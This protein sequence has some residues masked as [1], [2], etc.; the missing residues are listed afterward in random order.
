MPTITGAEGLGGPLD[1]PDEWCY[2]ER[3]TGGD[4]S[5]AGGTFALPLGEDDV[6]NV[7]TGGVLTRV[8]SFPPTPPDAGMT[9]VEDGTDLILKSEIVFHF[10]FPLLVVSFFVVRFPLFWG[11]SLMV[12]FRVF[13]L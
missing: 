2:G 4:V 3:P 6:T 11:I 13:H 9:A 10:P 12:L 7:V 8:D 1:F 5:G